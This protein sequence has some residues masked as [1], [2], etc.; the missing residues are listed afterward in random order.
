[1]V[2]RNIPDW[3]RSAF[4]KDNNSC[5]K[6]KPFGKR[7]KELEV[8][9][10]KVEETKAKVEDI[11]VSI[12]S[13]K[14][15]PVKEEKDDKLDELK[16]YKKMRDRQRKEEQEK[17]RRD[18]N[19]VVF[20]SAPRQDPNRGMRFVSCSEPINKGKLGSSRSFIKKKG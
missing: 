19:K 16:E 15:E 14:E 4:D 6:T 11:D 8:A 12:L 5:V 20:T 17:S 13:L 3:Q 7:I 10:A 18:E 2:K 1:M 9:Y